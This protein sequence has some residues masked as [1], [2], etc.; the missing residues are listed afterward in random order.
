MSDTIDWESVLGFTNEALDDDLKGMDEL[1][2]STKLFK[3]FY[4]NILIIY[5]YINNIL[6]I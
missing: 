3:V 1:S 4:F 6:L 5:V 2:L